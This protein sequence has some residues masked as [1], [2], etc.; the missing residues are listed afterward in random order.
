MKAA[1][2]LLPVLF[3]LILLLAGCEH[4]AKGQQESANS[5][6]PPAEIVS[7]GPP[8]DGIPPIDKPN[9]VS[10][11]EAKKFVRNGT[12]G[13]LVEHGSEARFYPYN[14]LVWHEIVNDNI[15]GKPLTITFCPLCATAIVFEREI[16]STVY[17]FGTSGKLYQSNLVMYDRQTD[18][19]WSQVLGKAIAGQMAGTKLEIYPS[20]TLSFGEAIASGANFTVLSTETGHLRNYNFDPYTDYYESDE[21]YFPVKHTDSRLSPKTLIYGISIGGKFKAYDYTTLKEKRQLED[22]LNG[23]KLKF[24]VTETEEVSVYDETAKKRIVGFNAFWFSWVTHHPEA[25]VWTG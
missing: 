12:Q 8:K 2:S 17:D 7:G 20:S 6:V 21:I 11:E 5:I 24:T 10:V 15:S 19:Y 13:I 18:S 16:N 3:A 1:Y 25:E 23:H 9:F 4:N 22:T 14:I